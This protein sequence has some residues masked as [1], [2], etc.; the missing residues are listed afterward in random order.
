MVTIIQ[1]P[2]STLRLVANPVPVSDIGT[3]TIATIVARMKEALHSQ[4]DGVAIAAPQIGESVRIFV[5]SQRA[6][7]KFTEDMVFI[8]PELVR[9]GRKKEDLS[10][11]CLSVRWKYGIVKRSTTATVRARN[12]EG[13]EFVMKGEGLLAQIF[14][15]EIDHL[16]GIL[17][18]DKAKDIE[19]VP[20]EKAHERT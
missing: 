5:V 17:F 1:E 10:E 19:D 7:K 14:Q 13:N 2:H 20:P 15:H 9:L 12:L 3:M 16:N 8:N 18:I 4:D 11:G 6:S